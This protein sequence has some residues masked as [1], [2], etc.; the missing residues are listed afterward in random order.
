MLAD[1]TILVNIP[2]PPNVRLADSSD[3]FVILQRSIPTT[4]NTPELDPVLV[5]AAERRQRF[6]NA[7]ERPPYH[8]SSCVT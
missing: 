5:L 4:L 8:R 7:A 2:L 1:A 6:W 3:R